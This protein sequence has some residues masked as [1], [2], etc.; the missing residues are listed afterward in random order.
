MQTAP[1]LNVVI[2]ALV[3][4]VGLAGSVLAALVAVKTLRSR[5]PDTE[6]ATRADLTKLEAYTHAGMHSIRNDIHRLTLQVALLKRAL[7]NG[8]KQR[9]Q[10]LED[11]M[12]HP[13]E[14]S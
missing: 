10:A 7:N 2:P 12:N 6:A 11:R 14:G 8:L 1:D 9:V 5:N 4:L 13:K 3:V